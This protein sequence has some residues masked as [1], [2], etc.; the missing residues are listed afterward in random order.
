[1]FLVR[2]P[3]RLVNVDEAISIRRLQLHRQKKQAQHRGATGPRPPDTVFAWRWNGSAFYTKPS[4]NRGACPPTFVVDRPGDRCV[5]QAP[6]PKTPYEVRRDPSTDIV[7]NFR[8]A[9]KNWPFRRRQDRVDAAYPD[10]ESE[11]WYHG[12]S[13]TERESARIYSRGQPH[14]WGG[15]DKEPSE[16]DKDA[17]R[18]WNA[19]LRGQDKRPNEQDVA[20]AKAI[21]KATQFEFQEPQ[22]V[23]RGVTVGPNGPMTAAEHQSA[24]LD[25]F[26]NMIGGAIKL[27]G[28][29][30]TTTNAGSAALFGK[31]GYTFEIRT[32]RG[33]PLRAASDTHLFD[34]VL[35]GHDWRYK[36]VD[37]QRNVFV[38][39]T[40]TDLVLVEVVDTPDVVPEVEQAGRTP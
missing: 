37:V 34:E 9:G 24:M 31:S 11:R 12:A 28:L 40:L 39:N 35:L 23:Y 14:S 16:A 38:G 7:A 33:L 10:T 21:N 13:E 29:T 26:E 19:F 36:V 27:S 30:S 4:L 15:K 17:Y 3:L 32:P 6:P 25:Y 2:R 8:R 1:M 20:R 18:R 5:T 22:M